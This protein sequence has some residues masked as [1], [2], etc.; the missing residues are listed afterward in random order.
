MG[1][2]AQLKLGSFRLS[3]DKNDINPLIMTLYRESDKH[4]FKGTAKQLKL[5]QKI[6]IDEDDY[7]E[8]YKITIMKYSAPVSAIRDRLDLMGF[9]RKIA[10]TDFYTSLKQKIDEYESWG[11]TSSKRELRI[12][13]Q[14]NL[15][16]WISNLQIIAKNNL[17]TTEIDGR[18]TNNYSPL[19]RYMLSSSQTNYG[20]PGYEFRNFLRLLLDVFHDS[21]FLEYDLTDLVGGGYIK[22]SDNLVEY[23]DDLISEDFPFSKKIIILT[24]GDTDRW[25]LQRSLKLLYPHL[26]EYFHFLDFNGSKVEGGAVAL[27][28][29]IKSFAGAGIIN[30][31]IALFDNDTAAESAIQS[32]MTIKLPKNIVFKQYPNISLCDNYPTQ[33]PTGIT[34]M[35]VNGLAGSI[36][37]YLGADILSNASGVYTPVQWKGYDSRLKQYQGEITNKN[38]LQIKFKQKLLDCESNPDSLSRYDWAGLQSIFDIIRVAFHTGE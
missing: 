13:H 37:L 3:F 6:D 33:G 14:L 8:N 9:T 27:A 12:L 2:Y 24:E 38:D 17:F 1:S 15:E 29:A 30:R 34:S 36:E 23:A 20:F 18:P 28:N 21:D 35:N 10:E 4:V 11:W 32:I 31:V 22:A 7:P 16:S 25:I 19:L 26:F 5:K